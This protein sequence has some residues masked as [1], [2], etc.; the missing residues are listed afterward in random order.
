MN[1]NEIVLILIIPFIDGCVSIESP[2]FPNGWASATPLVE[3]KCPDISGRYFILSDDRPD[4]DVF[5]ERHPYSPVNRSVYSIFFGSVWDDAR[6]DRPKF[7]DVVIKQ[8]DQSLT[9]YFDYKWFN[10][11]GQK[12]KVLKNKIDYECNAE[13]ISLSIKEEYGRGG[14]VGKIT[15]EVAFRKSVDGSLLANIKENVYAL[16]LVWGAPVPVVAKKNNWWR[17]RK[18]ADN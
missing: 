11:D 12:E 9:L 8:N 10:A 13:G 1:I 14:G 2:G 3:G 15:R 17:W 5:K 18:M 4:K 16:W 7:G 6:D